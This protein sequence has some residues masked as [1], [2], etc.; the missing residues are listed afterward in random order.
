MA[1]QKPTLTCTPGTPHWKIYFNEF[2]FVVSMYT[3]QEFQCTDWPK[4]GH[5]LG[6]IF[7]CRLQVS[8]CRLQVAGCCCCCCCCSVVVAV[9]VA[10]LLLLLVVVADAN[11]WQ[12]QTNAHRPI[13]THVLWPLLALPRK[14]DKHAHAYVHTLLL[15]RK[16]HNRQPVDGNSETHMR[17]MRNDQ[18]SYVW[19]NVFAFPRHF[20]SLQRQHR[21]VHPPSKEI[22]TDAVADQKANVHVMNL[23]ELSGYT[24]CLDALWQTHFRRKR[25]TSG[26]AEIGKCIRKL[27]PCVWWIFVWHL[28]VAHMYTPD[29]RDLGHDWIPSKNSAFPTIFWLIYNSKCCLSKKK[30]KTDQIILAANGILPPKDNNSEIHHIDMRGWINFPQFQNGVLCCQTSSSLGPCRLFLQWPLYLQ[31]PLWKSKM[32]FVC[33]TTERLHCG[34]AIDTDCCRRL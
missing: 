22:E 32:I 29:C 25:Y 8:G 16:P 14:A 18:H 5:A 19:S 1:N 13:C 34:S 7:F 27:N 10:L 24:Q 31:S 28:V 20:P 23:Y 30:W 6:S 17:Q 11:R 12:T 9:V 33:C 3:H 15:K 2:V 4:N 26:H 21:K